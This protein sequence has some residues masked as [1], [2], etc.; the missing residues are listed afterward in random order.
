MATSRSVSIV[1]ASSA[2]L[3]LA[4]AVPVHAQGKSAGKGTGNN[5]SGHKS[6]PPSSSP[7]PSAIAGPAAGAAGVPPLAWLDDASLLEPGSVSTTISAVRWSGTD[8][9]EVNFP[10]V[11]AA[12]GVTQRFQIGASVPHV[13][14]SADGTGPVGGVGTSY[15][16]TKIA[17]LTGAGASGVKLA[18]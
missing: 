8:L 7:L 17:L 9:S 18:V 12:I 15:I 13:V 4:V 14:G 1:I 16:S 3:L 10:I 6:T 11:Q 5:A 2:A